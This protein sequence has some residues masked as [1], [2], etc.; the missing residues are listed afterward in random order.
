MT[1]VYCCDLTDTDY[2][3][4]FAQA[5]QGRQKR[6][7]ACRASVV[8]AEVVGEALCR[9]NCPVAQKLT[10]LDAI[11]DAAKK[12]RMNQQKTKV[13]AFSLE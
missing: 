11:I 1:R 7:L 9:L 10:L 13:E 3:S 6:A 2:D 12:D 8:Q 4:L 5:S